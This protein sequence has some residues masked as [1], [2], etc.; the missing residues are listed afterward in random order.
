MVEKP[1]DFIE[2]YLYKY[3]M[4]RYA[5]ADLLRRLDIDEQSTSISLVVLSKYNTVSQVKSFTLEDNN[6]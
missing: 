3:D 5:W 2:V 6:A 1:L 4:D